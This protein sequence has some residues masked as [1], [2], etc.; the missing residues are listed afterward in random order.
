MSRIQ[1]CFSHGL[2]VSL[3]D[4]RLAL[5]TGQHLFCGY[6][7]VWTDEPTLCPGQTILPVRCFS[8][9]GWFYDTSAV[10][11]TL[12]PQRRSNALRALWRLKWQVAQRPCKHI[13]QRHSPYSFCISDLPAWEPPDSLSEMVLGSP[14]LEIHR[15]PSRTRQMGA[16]MDMTLPVTLLY[17]PS[18]RKRSFPHPLTLFS[19]KCMLVLC[20]QGQALGFTTARLPRVLVL[21]CSLIHPHLLLVK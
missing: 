9:S 16:D 19:L 3:P 8:K 11:T 14:T 10:H 15:R 1:T 21:F 20:P 4:R 13:G 18:L 6:D 5:W 12:K 17:C 2:Y 7:A